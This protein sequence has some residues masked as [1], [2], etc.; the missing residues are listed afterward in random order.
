MAKFNLATSFGNAVISKVNG[1][2]IIEEFKKEKG[3]IVSIG[4]Y[5]LSER[6]DD[7]IG[8]EYI[9]LAF[10]VKT[11]LDAEDA[12]IQQMIINSVSGNDSEDYDDYEESDEE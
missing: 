2:Y 9:S 3:E 10:T 1:I 12:V 6:L 4:K 11:E 5:N 8:T 7:I